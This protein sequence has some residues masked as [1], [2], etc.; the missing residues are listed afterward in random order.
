MAIT[1]PRRD[2]ISA[3]SSPAAGNMVIDAASAPPVPGGT[4]AANSQG[5]VGAGRGRVNLLH[6]M[7]GMGLLMF[8]C[9]CTLGDACRSTAALSRHETWS[10]S[11]MKWDMRAPPLRRHKGR[12]TAYLEGVVVGARVSPCRCGC[13]E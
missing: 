8:L 9:L 11:P 6:G 10:N 2:L 5:A 3:P 12:A 1:H 4:A 7:G 13:F